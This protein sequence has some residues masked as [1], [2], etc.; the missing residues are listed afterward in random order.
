MQTVRSRIWKPV[1]GALVIG[2]PAYY[3][4]SVYSRPTFEL[5]IKVA[6]PDGKTQMSTKTLPLLPMQTVNE[7]LHQNATSET[8]SRPYGITWKHTTASLSSN[9]PLEDAN[10]HQIIERDD[11]FSAN[12]PGDFLFFNVFDGHRGPETS[13]LL[14][15]ILINAVA[16]E[17][18]Q[19]ANSTAAL[20]TKGLTS[21]LFGSSTSSSLS[22]PE[23]EAVSL[24]IE[25][26]FT[27]LD[28]LLMDAPISILQNHLK[29]RS[30]KDMTIP[31]LSKD[32]QGM[33]AML[34]AVSGSCAL[35]TLIDT[36][37]RDLYVALAGDCRAVAGVWEP[38]Q[39]GKG[40]WKVDVL[41]EDQTGRNPSEVKR[42]K[43]EH[44]P[45]E[46]EYVVKNGRI[47][48]G[49][50]PSRAFGDARYKWNA[51]TQELLNQVYMV[52][53]GTPLR[54]A[55]LTLKTPP[56]V[57][58]KPVVTHRKLD[59][60]NPASLRFMVI[61]TDG[62]WDELSSEEVVSLVGGHL[63]G[64]KGTI[65]KDQLP[66]LVPTST[67]NAGLDGKPHIQKKGSGSWAFVDENVSSH[68]IR[69][70]LGGGDE[71]ALRKRV[72]IPAPYS[73][74]Y[75]DDITVTVV[76]WEHGKENQPNVSSLS[77]N[78]PVKSKL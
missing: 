4:Y 34:A 19:L 33:S 23:P 37:Q 50:E 31:D 67:A 32:P 73:R 46:A 12:S 59:F 16:L 5:P 78:E 68:L 57:T 7:R 1:A 10:S 40:I 60:E 43:S 17:L 53:N 74:R 70:A 25:K 71:M 15:R 54:K 20:N 44:P 48:G 45:D 24:T 14:S 52:G 9:D 8:V 6:G 11:A 75:R 72:S 38:T 65:S 41:T 22:A 2:G 36:A 66:S 35:V 58:A 77:S 28:S 47:L 27:K 18:S 69:N 76:W 61:A 13:R 64:L 63:A 56:Y 51:Q 39:D 30:P 49:L 42:I 26:A 3:T 21:K 29:G 62:L 55:P